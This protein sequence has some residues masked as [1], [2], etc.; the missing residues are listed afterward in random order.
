[1]EKAS[2]AF[3]AKDGF[4]YFSRSS[5]NHNFQIEIMYEPQ[6]AYLIRFTDIVVLIVYGVK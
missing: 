2:W 6:L 1:M 5:Y 4:K 3:L